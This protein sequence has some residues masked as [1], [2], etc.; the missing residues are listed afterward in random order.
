MLV[1]CRVRRQAVDLTRLGHS[2]VGSLL[3]LLLLWCVG[4]STK[5]ERYS[6]CLLVDCPRAKMLG[7]TICHLQLRDVSF[8]SFDVQKD[9]SYMGQ[10]RDNDV[11]GAKCNSLTDVVWCN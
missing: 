1:Q 11:G 2:Y 3:L 6:R 5:A 9:D 10:I 8:T 7:F 4:L